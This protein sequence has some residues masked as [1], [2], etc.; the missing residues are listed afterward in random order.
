MFDT[1]TDTH[2]KLPVPHKATEAVYLT[3]DET[4][5]QFVIDYY[6]RR[7]SK[8]FH[9]EG[10][11]QELGVGY[12]YSIPSSPKIDLAPLPSRVQAGKSNVLCTIDTIQLALTFPDRKAEFIARADILATCAVAGQRL[13]IKVDK[14]VA[15]TEGQVDPVATQILEKVVLPPLT[16]W[17]E[18]LLMPELTQGLGDIQAMLINATVANDQINGYARVVGGDQQ[19]ALGAALAPMDMTRVDGAGRVRAVVR[20]DALNVAFEGLV[21]DPSWKKKEKDSWNGFSGEAEVKATL[22]S[23]SIDISGDKATC[24]IKL[25]ASAR[26][27]GKAGPLEHSIK[28]KGECELKPVVR[29]KKLDGGARVAVELD[30]KRSDVDLNL[31]GDWGALDFARKELSKVLNKLLDG[32][33]DTIAVFVCNIQLVAVDINKLMKSAGLDVDAT[34]DE[35]GFRDGTLVG[36]FTVRERTKS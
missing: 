22:Y 35:F 2:K 4:L 11:S 10:Y 6:Y 21:D 8:Y 13:M 18:N 3:A 19:T 9:Q 15:T 28:L 1:V 12:L 14:A 30:V 26:V 23:P 25:K 24:K 27:E 29:L 20:E 5:L 31:K 16:R 17:L 36:Q 7:Y 33:L 34:A 32:L